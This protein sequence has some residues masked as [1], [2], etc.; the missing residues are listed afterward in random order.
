MH[1]VHLALF[2]ESILFKLTLKVW[3]SVLKYG[4]L[5]PLFS[6][7]GQLSSTATKM[8]LLTA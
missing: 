4:D 8:I 7:D 1:T 5:K 2:Y 6:Y 3:P